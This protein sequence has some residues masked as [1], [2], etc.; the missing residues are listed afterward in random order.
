MTI[1]APILALRDQTDTLRDRLIAWTH[2]NSGSRNIAGLERMRMTLRAAFSQFPGVQIEEISLEGTQAKA[3]SVRCRPSA[4]KQVM[5]SGHYDTVFGADH[6]FQRCL[7]INANTLRGPGVA[8]MKGGLLA[9]L[10]ALETFEQ[11]PEA[12]EVGWEA[13]LTPDEE[14]G[15]DASAPII[16]ATAKRHQLGLVF[17]PARSNGDLVQSRKGT[18]NFLLTVHGRAAHAGHVPN[19][20]RN[21][22]NALAELLIMLQRIPEELPGVLV[23]VGQI[24]GGSPALNVVADFARAGLNLRITRAA[25][26]PLVLTR[27]KELLA[28]FNAREGLSVELSGRFDCPPKECGPAEE[29]VFAEWQRCGRDLGVQAFSWVHTGGGSDGNLLSAAGLPNL[30]GIGPVGDGMHSDR[31]FCILPTLVERTQIAALFLS[32]WANGEVN[33][34]LR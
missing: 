3:L 11:L 29:A 33:V 5:L 9:M 13:L 20:G 4:K 34:P 16:L 10:A 27:M 2:I 15:S 19:N 32:R 28:P 23:N 21:A 12:S 8:D 30:D 6:P 1:P 18:G 26:E 24:E 7:L 17:E 14:I 25:D 31:E 22:I